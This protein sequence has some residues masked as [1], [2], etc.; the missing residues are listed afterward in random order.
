MLKRLYEALSCPL[1]GIFN[2]S[3]L[4]GIF[5]NMMKVAEVIPLYKGNERDLVVNYRPL[6]LLMTISKVLEKLIYIHLY[7]YLEKNNILFDSQYGFRTKQSCEHAISELISKLLHSKED[8][9]KSSVLFLDLSKAFDTLNHSI[10]LGKLDS[11]GIRGTQLNWFKSYLDRRKLSAKVN[12][13][14]SM[15]EYSD[16]YDITCGAAQGSSLGP[17]LFVVFCNDINLLP[18]IETLILFADN[19][20]LLNSSKNNAYLEYSMKHDLKL[21]DEWFKA[22]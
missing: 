12:T 19:M 9:K 1:T 21:L 8:G 3:I 4:Q 5:P 10:L 7:K 20:T 15:I 14:S 13:S 2:Q 22:N 11:Y 17:L 16:T 6:S 18:L